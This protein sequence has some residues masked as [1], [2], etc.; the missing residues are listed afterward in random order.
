MGERQREASVLRAI[1]WRREHVRKQLP[2]EAAIQGFIGGSL[3]VLLS[4]LAAQGLTNLKFS[5]PNGLP[6]SDD[7][8]AFLGSQYVAP[9]VEAD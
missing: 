3:G 7:P 4:W 5:L 8:A 1:G 9:V 2:A 6:K